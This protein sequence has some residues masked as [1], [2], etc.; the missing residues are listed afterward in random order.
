MNPL[1]TV[2]A[3]L[4][5]PRHVKAI[6]PAAWTYLAVLDKQT[7]P[8]GTVNRGDPIAAAKLG[9]RMGLSQDTILRHLDRLQKAGYIHLTRQPYGWVIRVEKPKKLF[10]KRVGKTAD[11]RVGT[12]AYSDQGQSPQ[13]CGSESARLRTVYK[14]SIAS[15]AI[16]ASPKRGSTKTVLD[17]DRCSHSPKCGNLPWHVCVLIAEAGG[18]EP[19]D[20]PGADLSQAKSLADVPDPEI[21]GTVGY[22]L[23]QSDFWGRKQPISPSVVLRFLPIYRKQAGGR[24]NGHASM[25]EAEL[26]AYA[27][28]R[29]ATA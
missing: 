27:D 10:K 2:S 13:S 3:G 19:V 24:V 8:D 22:I 21:G 26:A 23:A 18:L 9:A 17:P 11:S 15:K 14:E 4:L 7:S 16:P 5:D 25:T 20:F 12:I 28:Q 1:I 6:G 29:E